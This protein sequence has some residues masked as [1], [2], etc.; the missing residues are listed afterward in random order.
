M[1]LKLASFEYLCSLGELKVS[2]SESKYATWV[3]L[4]FVTSERQHANWV[5]LKL[6]S[7]ER[8]H[9]DWVHLIKQGSANTKCSQ[10]TSIAITNTIN[11]AD[12]FK[13]N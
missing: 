8:K 11:D 5:H 4:K 1:Y 3:H 12:I 7:S 13:W 10:N 2:F 9:S 6:V